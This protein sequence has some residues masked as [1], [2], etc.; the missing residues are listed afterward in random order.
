MNEH[1]LKMNLIFESI[2]LGLGIHLLVKVPRP[3]DSEKT[4]SV[5]ESSYHLLLPV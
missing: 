3:E 1:F 4:F 5:F 2:G